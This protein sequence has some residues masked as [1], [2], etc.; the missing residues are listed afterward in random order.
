MASDLEALSCVGTTRQPDV[1]DEPFL[2]S[3]IISSSKFTQPSIDLCHSF[4][5]LAAYDIGH[6][7]AIYRLTRASPDCHLL[8]VIQPDIMM[9]VIG[10]HVSG[11][12]LNL[13]KSFSDGA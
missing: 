2:R 7:L 13:F 3:S 12:V 11:Q 5:H 1:A 6:S 8:Y 4:T 10:H 9:Y